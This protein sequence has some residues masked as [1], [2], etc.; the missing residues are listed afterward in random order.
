MKRAIVSIVFSLVVILTFSCQDAEDKQAVLQPKRNV[1]A[2]ARRACSNQINYGFLKPNDDY[3]Y[4][5]EGCQSF[6]VHRGSTRQFKIKMANTSGS[7]QYIVIRFEHPDNP[8]NIQYSIASV[9]GGSTSSGSPVPGTLFG[10]YIN[11]SA[12]VPA[13]T[14]Y[15]LTL[16]VYGVIG[17]TSSEN[18]VKLTLFSP[19]EIDNTNDCDGD[20]NMHFVLSD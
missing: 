15:E 3:V 10:A 11:W 16:N 8:N 17:S 20:D 19:C 2:G 12:S 5:S 14:T 9:T 6:L 18:G 13:Y 7:V 1:N 4:D